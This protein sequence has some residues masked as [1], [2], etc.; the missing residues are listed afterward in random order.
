MVQLDEVLNM[1][2]AELRDR[3]LQDFSYV[4]TQTMEQW[5][6]RNLSELKRATA[7]AK[8]GGRPIRGLDNDYRVLFMERGFRHLDVEAVVQSYRDAKTRVIFLDHEGTLAPDRNTFM[9]PYDA[10][11]AAIIHGAGEPPDERVL[12]CLR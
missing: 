2:A 9:R 3:F 8:E 4:S 12:D 11:N 10:S 6:E 1:S 5:V 7:E